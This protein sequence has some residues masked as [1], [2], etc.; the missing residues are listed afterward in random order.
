LKDA[1]RI[2]KLEKPGR[3]RRKWEDNL[4]TDIKGIGFEDAD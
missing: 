1:N 2:F 3:L 4:K